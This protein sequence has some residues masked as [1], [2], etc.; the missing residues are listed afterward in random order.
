M[1]T[2]VNFQE[3]QCTARRL[4]QPHDAVLAVLPSPVLCDRRALL[5]PR[6]VPPLPGLSPPLAVLGVSSGCLC[7][8]VSGWSAARGC[9]YVQG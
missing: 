3:D 1:A 7:S 6:G 8:R 4:K 9:R 2:V 5:L